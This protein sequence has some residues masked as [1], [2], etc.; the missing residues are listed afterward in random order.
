MK[1]GILVEKI[2]LMFEKWIMEW[3]EE[4]LEA[5]LGDDGEIT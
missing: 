3:E 4:S 2:L 1:E 5:Y